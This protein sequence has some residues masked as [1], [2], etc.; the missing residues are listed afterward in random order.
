[1]TYTA[2]T[3][4]VMPAILLNCFAHCEKPKMNKV[5]FKMFNLV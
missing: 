4:N 2:S 5:Q 1:M 3:D